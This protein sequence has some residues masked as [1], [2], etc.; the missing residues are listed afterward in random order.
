MNDEQLISQLQ[1]TIKQIRAEQRRKAREA[2]NVRKREMLQL[3]DRGWTLQ[4]IATKYGVSR[5]RVHQIIGATGRVES[6]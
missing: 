5:Q 2:E 3:R 1:N 6:Q 4:K